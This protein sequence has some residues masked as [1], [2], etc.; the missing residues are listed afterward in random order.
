ML[1]DFAIV[2]PK[3]F[4]R[5]RQVDVCAQCHG[6]LGEPR[7]PAF[8]FVPGRPLADYV[9]LVVP[10]ADAKLD[11]HGNQVALLERSRCYQSSAKMTCTTCHEVHAPERPAAAYSDRCLACH[12]PENCGEYPKLGPDIAKNCIDC[13]MQ[14]QESDVIVSNVASK[15]VKMRIRNHWI[16]I[17]AHPPSN[18]Q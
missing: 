12:Q 1:A 15:Q 11:V 5:A 3:S 8:S 13:H 4:P 17:Y 18:P 7:A 14:V 16:K 2:N 9:Q 10:P 6:G